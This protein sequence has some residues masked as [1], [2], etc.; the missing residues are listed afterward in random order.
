MREPLL[1]FGGTGTRAS[2]MQ[3]RM[4]SR[5]P[6]ED[7]LLVDHAVETR[8]ALETIC[9]GRRRCASRPHAEAC[10]YTGFDV[11]PAV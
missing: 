11:S 3:H 1:Q 9:G 2:L 6:A 7:S 4:E 5:V 8:L 10:G